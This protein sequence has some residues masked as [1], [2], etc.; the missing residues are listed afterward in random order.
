MYTAAFAIQKDTGALYRGPQVWAFRLQIA[1]HELACGKAE[2]AGQAQYLIGVGLDALIDAA[3]AAGV[4]LIRKGGMPI[5]RCAD[6]VPFLSYFSVK[7]C[8]R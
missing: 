5:K 7:S 4:A 2:V 1:L 8:A 3:S 6:H